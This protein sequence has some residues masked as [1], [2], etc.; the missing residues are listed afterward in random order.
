MRATLKTLENLPTQSAALVS[1]SVAGRHSFE[2]GAF[3]RPAPERTASRIGCSPHAVHR[4][5]CLRVQGQR[6]KRRDIE[7]ST[8]LKL[9]TE[10]T[11][12]SASDLL[13]ASLKRI[14]QNKM[15]QA[16]LAKAF[17]PPQQVNTEPAGDSASPLSRF[18]LSLTGAL[19]KYVCLP[20]ERPS[21]SSSGC[22][23]GNSQGRARRRSSPVFEK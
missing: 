23:S 3:L 6:V 10:S 5:C 12:S 19:G 14:R 9:R 17:F 4:G 1:S 20:W 11:C 22:V 16:V 8:Y 21:L 15:T 13:V 18:R 2:H 7:L